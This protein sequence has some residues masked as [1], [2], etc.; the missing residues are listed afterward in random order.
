MN[1]L[2]PFNIFYVAILLHAPLRQFTFSTIITE[3]STTMT[4]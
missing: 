4:I 3:T 2:F 1:M